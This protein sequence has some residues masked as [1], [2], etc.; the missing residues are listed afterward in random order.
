MT[1]FSAQVGVTE[2][3]AARTFSCPAAD[4]PVNEIG[5]SFTA[6]M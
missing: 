2:R 3:A 6:F 4:G 5:F 1:A